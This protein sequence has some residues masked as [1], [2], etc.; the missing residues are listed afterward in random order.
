MTTIEQIE[1]AIIR[2][3]TPARKLAVMH[4]L[5]RQAWELKASGV[6]WQRPD[7]TR[8]QVQARVREIFR[9]AAT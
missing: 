4:A 3:M 1:T 9:G 5:W 7:W 8:E 2:R 6:R